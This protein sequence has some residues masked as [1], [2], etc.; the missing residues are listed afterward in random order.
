MSSV[1]LYTL[2][3]P[4]YYFQSRFEYLVTSIVGT[5]MEY[6]SFYYYYSDELVPSAQYVC[7]KSDTKSYRANSL[8]KCVN[9][10]QL[11]T[12]DKPC[13][14]I[15]QQNQVTDMYANDE[16]YVI[17][18]ILAGSYFFTLH[19]FSKVVFDFSLIS[20]PYKANFYTYNIENT[21]INGIE[22]RLG[23]SRVE[24]SRACSDNIDKLYRF[25]QTVLIIIFST[26]P[27]YKIG[28][29]FFT[30]AMTSFSCPPSISPT[31]QPSV[32]STYLPTRIPTLAPLASQY[33]TFTAA[34]TN[35][36]PT[37]KPVISF[38]PTS[39]GDTAPT[40]SS[41]FAPTSQPRRV[42]PSSTRS[43]STM[44]SNWISMKSAP[45]ARPTVTA[46]TTFGPS[47]NTAHGTVSQTLNSYIVILVAVV[48]SLL[49]LVS[50][51]AVGN[52]YCRKLAIAH[53]N[54][55]EADELG[56]TMG[57]TTTTATAA[58]ATVA[59]TNTAVAEEG[60]STVAETGGFRL[61]SRQRNRV[62][63]ASITDDENLPIA[64]IYN[65]NN[66]SVPTYTSPVSVFQSATVVEMI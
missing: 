29:S 54:G 14:H 48:L 64:E 13:K 40:A 33:P 21:F 25:N 12:C 22:T 1:S 8:N 44:Q 46:A 10:K 53:N 23:G 47:I 6:I 66:D 63:V 2:I 27:I 28:G 4:I 19:P 32:I 24:V 56:I 42:R 55:D 9:Q 62:A 60:D 65:E 31:F 18:S 57:P 36:N 35:K 26:S 52:F 61:F 50:L 7:L 51:F 45:S 30:G 39:A 58:A 11:M 3:S 15:L 17:S 37:A 38:I 43:P 41:S 49:V 5:N 34:P 16:D 20:G 59:Y